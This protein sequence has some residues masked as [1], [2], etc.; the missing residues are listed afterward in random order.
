MKKSSTTTNKT[1]QLHWWNNYTLG[2]DHSLFFILG[3]LKLSILPLDNE[4]Q[5][6]YQ[7]LSKEEEQYQSPTI[8][9]DQHPELKHTERFVI[10]KW[11]NQIYL[12]PKL[13]D[14]PVVVRPKNNLYLLPNQSTT[15]YVSTA[16]WLAV[17][18]GNVKSAIKELRAIALSDTW[19]G[20]TPREGE[21]CYAARTSGKISR[22]QIF[23][24]P[25]RAVTP[26]K[27]KNSG[28]DVFAIERIALPTPHLSL[29][30]DDDA[31][32]WTNAVSIDRIENKDV[33]SIKLES[34]PPEHVKNAKLVTKPREQ[35]SDNKL[36]KTLKHLLS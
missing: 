21:I 24:A 15:L 28:N 27:L 16:V 5:V 10:N 18:L 9:T 22:E 25:F 14:R 36:T 31:N 11:D 13:A 19:M 34:K 23:H 32:L 12:A 2:N 7:Y 29:Y 1:N 33:A 3:E 30:E 35:A 6:S 17:Y 8:L 26:V 4:V 20:A